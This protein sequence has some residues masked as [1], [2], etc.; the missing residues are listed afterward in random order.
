[1]TTLRI[2]P[3]FA[4]LLLLTAGCSRKAGI[5]GTWSGSIALPGD[6]GSS[7][8][9]I[10]LREDGTFHKKGGAQAE[11]SGTYTVKDNVLTE[12]FTSYSVQG[13]IMS[14]PEDTPNVERDSFVLDGDML[15]LTPSGSGLPTVLKRKS[16]G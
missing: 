6:G 1:M 8:S 3:L 13:H 11:Y 12:T 15:T 2:V 5:V 7:P 10:T 16:S 14:I 4:I 9:E